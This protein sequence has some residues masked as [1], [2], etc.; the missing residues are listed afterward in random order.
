MTVVEAGAH[1]LSA[2]D[3]D[4]S[5]GV[6]RELEVMF[7]VLYTLDFMHYDINMRCFGL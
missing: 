4:M 5:G 3:G 2:I 6:E 1:V 7:L